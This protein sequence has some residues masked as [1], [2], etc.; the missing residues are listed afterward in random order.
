MELQDLLVLVDQQAQ[1][2]QL[3]QQV[4]LLLFLA[5]PDLQVRKVLQLTS[6]DQLQLQRRYRQQETLSTMR[7]S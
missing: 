3:V 7:T 1:T 4:P 2:V 5:Q 6:E